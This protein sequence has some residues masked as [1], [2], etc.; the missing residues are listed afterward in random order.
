MQVDMDGSSC[1]HQYLL[2]SRKLATCPNFLPLFD[3]TQQQH[4]AKIDIGE[5]LEIDCL[6]ESQNFIEQERNDNSK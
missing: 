4:F 2:W 5:S 3:Q 1:F 6:H